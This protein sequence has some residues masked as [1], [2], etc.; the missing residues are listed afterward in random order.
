[1]T[2]SPVAVRPESLPTVEHVPSA[3]RSQADDA[4]F[5]AA[6]YGLQPDAWQYRVLKAW[7]AERDGGL[8]ASSRAGLAVP[9][10]NG[11]NAVLEVRELFGMIG[12][13]ERFL[14][15]A[16]EVKTARKAFLRLAGF[17]ENKREWPE[18][19]QLV[20]SIRKTNGQEA[21]ELTNG[22]GVEFVA[23]SRGSGRGY[24]VDVLVADEAQ[25]LTDEQLEALLPTISSAPT[26]NPQTLFTG[27]P[28]P[29]G[30]TAEVFSRMR[31]DALAGQDGRLSWHEWSVGADADPGDREL[32]F[33]ANPALGVRL[34]P[35][36]VESELAQMST[37]GFL[38]ERLGCWSSGSTASVIRPDVWA[39][40]EDVDSAPDGR[41]VFAVD[42]P[43]NREACSI[44]VAGH[45]PDGL[46]HVELV[47]HEPGTAWVAG[48]VKELHRKWKA[49]VAVDPSSPAGSLI[50]ELKKAGVEVV[51]VAGRE[52]AQA[53]GHFVDMVSEGS[54]RH[55]GQA[56]LNVAVDAGRKRT[57]GDAWAW[58][59]K[60]TS[61]DISPLVGATLA[62]WTVGKPPKKRPKSGKASF[63]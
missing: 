57:L 19:V 7:L 21:I 61:S 38:R 60:D 4:S 51:E 34:Q 62:L 54:V 12:L 50:P 33:A 13:G 55:I 17:F 8:W 35:D 25:E 53:C 42:M 41:V 22:G 27:T 18:L 2:S 29:P 24:T 46:G 6:A 15:T 45:R 36:V 28:P 44:V 40:L 39:V 58:H 3:V 10:Q 56:K 16:H 9:R 5:L 23:R 47:A 48:R 1:L 52:M 37:E 26:G 59:R 31:A 49:E 14:H 32:W 20:R 11:K 43:P 63:L 30:S